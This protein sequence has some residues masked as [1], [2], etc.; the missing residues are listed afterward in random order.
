[1]KTPRMPAPVAWPM[2][3]QMTVS[4]LILASALALAASGAQ[5]AVFINEI[6]YDNLDVD[7]GEAIEVVATAGE[8]LSDYDIVLYNGSNNQTYDTDAVPAGV[9]ADA[10]V[11][12]PS[13]S[14]TIH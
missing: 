1:M 2:A 4:R 6:H 5:A 11:R 10:A 7:A 9:P 3:S 8:N 13:V 12:R 14:S